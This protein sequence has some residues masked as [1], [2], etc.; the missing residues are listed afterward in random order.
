M[1]ETE[2]R[3]EAD[4]LKIL[5]SSVSPSPAPLIRA[6]L[7]LSYAPAR[8]RECL[9][10][11]LDGDDELMKSIQSRMG[12]T[13]EEVVY[14]QLLG[15]ITRAWT[16]R[17]RRASQG[18]D[19]IP[20][21]VWNILFDFRRQLNRFGV[22]VSEPMELAFTDAQRNAMRVMREDIRL[23]EQIAQLYDN[24]PNFRHEAGRVTAI[25]EMARGGD[26]F[27]GQDVY[28]DGMR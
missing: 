1:S 6:R 18:A 20:G 7:A 21:V 24:N 11:T 4:I 16:M 27:A 10:R 3:T 19:A 26:I 9:K 28:R 22:P 8:I 2:I 17:S 23:L 5:E 15:P 14:S 12:E 25:R 13:S